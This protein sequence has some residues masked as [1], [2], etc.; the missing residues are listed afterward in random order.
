MLLQLV[1]AANTE[2]IHKRIVCAYSERIIVVNHD[3][4]TYIDM[5]T[6]T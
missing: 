5:H 6:C 1:C 2:R 3:L 4:D